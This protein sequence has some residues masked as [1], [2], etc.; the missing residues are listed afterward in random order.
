MAA[1]TREKDELDA[2]L[3]SHEAYTELNRLML[4]ERVKRQGEVQRALAALE[5]DWL[6][7]HARLEEVE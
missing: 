4:A 7:A 5:D 2:W 6:W 3:A 1:L